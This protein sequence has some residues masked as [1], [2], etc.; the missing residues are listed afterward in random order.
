VPASTFAVMTRMAS[1][2]RRFIAC[3]C[4]RVF[5]IEETDA[6][7]INEGTINAEA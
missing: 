7:G 2:K 5:E 1:L 4:E 3:L 6:R